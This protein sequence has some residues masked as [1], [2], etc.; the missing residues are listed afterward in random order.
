MDEGMDASLDQKIACYWSQKVA[1]CSNSCGNND[2]KQEINAA[3]S[4]RNGKRT[5]GQ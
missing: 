1:S 4:E 2:E 5:G 3:Q